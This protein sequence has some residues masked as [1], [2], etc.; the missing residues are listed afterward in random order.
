MTGLVSIYNDLGNDINLFFHLYCR[1]KK[2]GLEMDDVKELLRA[3]QELKVLLIRV[4]LYNDHIKWQKEQLKQLDQV[5]FEMGIQPEN[6]DS[7][8]SLN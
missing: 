1:I 8:Y 3:Q 4:E 2:E 7:M 5:L 6:Y